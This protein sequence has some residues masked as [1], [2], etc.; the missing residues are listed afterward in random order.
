VVG[1]DNSRKR[2][3]TR[4]LL[5]NANK[6]KVLVSE[7]DGRLPESATTKRKFDFRVNKRRAEMD[8]QIHG[9]TKQIQS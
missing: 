8:I 7:N 3:T 5:K 9:F 1:D 6:K 2:R 4:E